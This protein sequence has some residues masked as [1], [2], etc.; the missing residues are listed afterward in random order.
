MG[1]RPGGG[2]YF[3]YNPN[4]QMVKA[5]VALRQR[6]CLKDTKWIY[7]WCPEIETYPRA[8]ASRTAQ[9]LMNEAFANLALGMNC[10]SFLIMDTRY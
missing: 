1:A 7:A 10:L 5:F 9:G 3:D 8:F 4:D 6:R 2:A